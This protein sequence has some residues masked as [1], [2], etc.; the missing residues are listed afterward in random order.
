MDMGKMFFPIDYTHNILIYGWDA[1]SAGRMIRTFIAVFL[2]AKRYE[3]I[4][5][6]LSLKGASIEDSSD[7]DQRLF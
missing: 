4:F 3:Y 6:L 2:L 1:N 7:A 5:L